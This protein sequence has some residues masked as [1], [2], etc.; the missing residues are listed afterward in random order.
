MGKERNRKDVLS[1]PNS[2]SRDPGE[3]RGSQS[4]SPDRC[5]SSPHA[6]ENGQREKESKHPRVEASLKTIRRLCFSV[7]GNTTTEA[8][9]SIVYLVNAKRTLVSIA[10]LTFFSNS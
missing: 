4:C 6:T 1:M 10:T 9:Y 5:R 8:S 2:L 7:P 3:D